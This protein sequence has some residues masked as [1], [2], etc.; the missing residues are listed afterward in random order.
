[1]LEK[2]ISCQIKRCHWCK[3]L[4][5]HSSTNEMP[6]IMGNEVTITWLLAFVSP[7]IIIHSNKSTNPMHQTLRFIACRLNIV[8]HVSGILMPIIR[9][10]STAVAASG[11]PFLCVKDDRKGQFWGLRYCLSKLRSLFS[12]SVRYD[13]TQ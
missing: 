7:C 13:V 6:V 5:Y 12:F 2:N 9:S 1:V 3:F 10:S 4:G 11:L 8:Q